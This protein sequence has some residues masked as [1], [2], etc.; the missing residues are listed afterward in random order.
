L[1]DAA[2]DDAVTEHVV[3]VIVP[4]AGGTAVGRC[5]FED[6]VVALAQAFFD[7]KTGQEPAVSMFALSHS[8]TAAPRGPLED[9]VAQIAERKYCRP[10]ARPFRL[11]FPRDGWSV[12]G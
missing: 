3:V 2:N 4:F 5:A 1:H 11:G 12:S 7:R 10:H 9:R 6:E 8:P